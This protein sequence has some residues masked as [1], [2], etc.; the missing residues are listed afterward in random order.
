MSTSLQP[1]QVTSTTLRNNRSPPLPLSPRSPPPFR[2][3]Y[4]GRSA[5]SGR[6]QRKLSVFASASSASRVM[7]AVPR[8]VMSSF[9]RPRLIASGP[10]ARACASVCERSAAVRPCS[11]STPSSTS[12]RPPS[13]AASRSAMSCSFCCRQCMLCLKATKCFST[14]LSCASA[15]SSLSFTLRSA[16]ARVSASLVAAAP[17]SS[18]SDLVFVLS[19]SFGLKPRT[20]SVERRTF[21][22]NWAFGSTRGADFR[23]SAPSAGE[24]SLAPACLLMTS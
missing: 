8:E 11:S 22:Q 12:M 23:S 9:S 18:T 21:S 17:S 2:D 7:F 1:Q 16:A 10:S 3:V 24:A 13:A 4:V 20:S 14:S 19:L 6:L 15:S 5:Q